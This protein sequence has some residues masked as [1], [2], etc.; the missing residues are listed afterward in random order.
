[1]YSI[2]MRTLRFNNGRSPQFRAS[3]SRRSP[4]SSS[5]RIGLFRAVRGSRAIQIRS[6]R[7][8]QR[9][10]KLYCFHAP[11]VECIGKG[12]AQAPDEFRAKISV[13]TTNARAPGG[14][15]VL[16]AKSLPGNPYDGHTLASVLDET[17]ALTGRE[18]ERAFVDKGYRGRVVANAIGCWMYGLVSSRPL[19][20]RI[21]HRMVREI[22]K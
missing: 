22:G 17:Q 12:K 19:K 20:S 7:Q 4:H 5:R 13:V 6:Q 1:M 21:E 9:G 2:G 16:H 11:E 10:W 8:R 14:Q 18:I 15:F 3:G